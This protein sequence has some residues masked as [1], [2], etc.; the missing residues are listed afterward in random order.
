VRLARASVF[1]TADYLLGF[2][3]TTKRVTKK[4]LRLIARAHVIVAAQDLTGI[5]HLMKDERSRKAVEVL[6]RC[7]DCPEDDHG[8]QR[9]GGAADDARLD[10]ERSNPEHSGP[11]S[12][13]PLLSLPPS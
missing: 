6:E 13:A 11:S 3:V 5:W 8:W 12:L 7:V 9:A 1:V 4:F 10:F 2:T